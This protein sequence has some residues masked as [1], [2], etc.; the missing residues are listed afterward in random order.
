LRSANEA[1]NR[2][3][4]RADETEMRWAH[5]SLALIAVVAMSGCGSYGELREEVEALA[6]ANSKVIAKCQKFG[7][8]V[9]ESPSYGCAY[10]APG[11][12]RSVALALA[13]RL[14]NEQFDSVCNR[15]PLD[16][17]IEFEAQREQVLV[18]A[19]V[20][21]A[22]SVITISADG[23][24]PL[25]IFKSPRF[26]HEQYRQAPRG[27]VIVKIVAGEYEGRDIRTDWDSCADYVGALDR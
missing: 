1:I 22:G 11:T 25:N 23:E 19:R 15:N 24:Q 4:A 10:F 7:A 8:Y 21:G 13:R 18:Y 14:A 2:E 3:S 26:I 17:T 9:I 16:G 20:S 5:W 12:R 27:Y 6:P